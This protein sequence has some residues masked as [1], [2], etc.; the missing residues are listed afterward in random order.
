[1]I[2]PQNQLGPGGGSTHVPLGYS[3]AAFVKSPAF[4]SEVSCAV[5]PVS[6]AEERTEHT[7]REPEKVW[8]VRL[9][10]RE[11]KVERSAHV[12]L[13]VV[14]EEGKSVPPCRRSFP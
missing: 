1:M 4:P 8:N 2:V 12:S 5:D 6:S 11:R 7:Y 10:R 13:D 14:H 9:E 3:V